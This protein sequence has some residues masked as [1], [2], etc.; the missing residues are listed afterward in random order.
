[1]DSRGNQLEKPLELRIKVL[2]INDNE[3]VYKQDLFVGSIE[4]LSAARKG[5]SLLFF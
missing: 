3:P 2:G 1:M 5:A 4:E